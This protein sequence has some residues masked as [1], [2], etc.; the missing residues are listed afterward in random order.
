MDW[1]CSNSKNEKP[2]KYL[3]WL[4]IFFSLQYKRRQEAREPSPRFLSVEDEDDR[5]STFSYYD[6]G[7]VRGQTYTY[8]SELVVS[9]INPETGAPEIHEASPKNVEITAGAVQG[10]I[11]RDTVWTGGTWALCD[12]IYVDEDATLTIESATGEVGLLRPDHR[13]HLWLIW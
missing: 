11:T 12:I 8:T 3:P 7:L 4:F 1:K 13:P 10:T 9:W 6:P 2:G 5:Y